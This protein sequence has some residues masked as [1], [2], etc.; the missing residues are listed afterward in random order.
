[1]SPRRREPNGAAPSSRPGPES[2]TPPRGGPFPPPRKALAQHFLVDRRVLSRI[3]QAAELDTDDLVLEVG[4]GRGVLTRAL[5]QRAGRVIA[6]ELDETLAAA[7]ERSLQEA[8]N[9][10]VVRA[11]ARQVPIEDLV[12]KEGPYK[13]VANLP[14]YAAG[15]IIRRFLE[16]ERRP[17]LMVVMVQREVAENMTA[18][19]GRMTFMSVAVQL[20]GRPRI[21]CHVPPRAFRPPPKVDSAV[22]RVDVYPRPALEVASIQDFFRLVGAGFSSPRKQIHNCLRRRLALSAETVLQALEEAGVDPRRRPQTLALEEWGRLYDA[23]RRLTGAATI[24]GEDGRHHEP[25]AEAEGP[26]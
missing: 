19:P 15:P 7:L 1:M 3:L 14:Y 4:P 5:A 18:P 13:L 6:V 22:V 24:A 11:D 10:T 2:D 16:A 26:G 20:F 23:F 12:G 8:P 9:V 21:V 25:D 17:T